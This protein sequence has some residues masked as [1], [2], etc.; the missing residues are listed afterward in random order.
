MSN[1]KAYYIYCFI[2]VLFVLSPAC[3]P[4]FS[5]HKPVHYSATGMAS[6][7]GPGFIGRK[8]ASGERYRPSAMTAAHKD[9]PFGTSVK[10]TSLDTGKSV[11]VRIN[12]RGPYVGE[13]LIDLSYGAAKKIGLV[14]TGTA[15][16]A[17]VALHVE[18]PKIARQDEF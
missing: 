3:A 14:R 7:Y 2:F 8:T 10:V 1:K 18:P 17:V 11:V 6:W 16:V 13:R 12:D 9:L 15:E 5:Q 4:Y